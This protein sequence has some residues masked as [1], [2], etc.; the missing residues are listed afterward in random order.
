MLIL[1]SYFGHR[2]D[3]LQN[4]S[5]NHSDIKYL[6]YFV[7]LNSEINKLKLIDLQRLS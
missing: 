2:F 3:E 5:S 7:D 6:L 4:H 1:N